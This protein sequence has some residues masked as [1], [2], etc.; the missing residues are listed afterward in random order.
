MVFGRKD[1][2]NYCKSNEEIKQPNV[3]TGAVLS[4]ASNYANYIT[5][6]YLP[7]D[8]GNTTL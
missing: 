8:G 7:V 5:G 4:Y 6:G 3:L 1:K 2:I